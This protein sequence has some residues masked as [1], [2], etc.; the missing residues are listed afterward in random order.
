MLA[1]TRLKLKN[2]ESSINFM[3][4]QH[5]NTLKDL[6]KE[7]EKLQKKNASTS[8]H[9]IQTPHVISMCVIIPPLSVGLSFQLTMS[10]SQ[11]GTGG[12]QQLEEELISEIAK[13]Q[14]SLSKEKEGVALLQYQVDHLLTRHSEDI[15]ARDDTINQLNNELD[16][17]A[18]IITLLTQQLCRVREKLKQEIE[19]RTKMANVCVCQHCFVHRKMSSID[20]A[21]REKDHFTSP[22]MDASDIIPSPP[23]SISPHPPS[24]SISP[25]PPLSSAG[26]N[27]SIKRRASTPI[28]RQS[29]SPKN[30]LTNLSLDLSRTSSSYQQQ[31]HLK[32]ARAS[33]DTGSLSAELQQLLSMNEGSVKPVKRE[34]R[35]VLPPIPALH[36]DQSGIGTDQPLAWDRHCPQQSS[37]HLHPRLILTKTKGLSSAPGTLRVLHYAPRNRKDLKEQAKAEEDGEE[38]EEG[39]ESKGTLFLVKESDV[40]GPPPC[41]AAEGDTNSS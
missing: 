39:E 9:V 35:P 34:A 25:H 16:A 31:H 23:L 21:L 26:R 14:S 22:S 15:T 2:A 13:L 28:R 29:S 41:A 3:Q 6:H 12:Q 18:N 20:G 40:M 32:P 5:A 11:A 36:A 30:S 33:K 8:T 10:G 7:I 19:S 37:E 38:A 27:H 1:R 17:K 24:S 4:E